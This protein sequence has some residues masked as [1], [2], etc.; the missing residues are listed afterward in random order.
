MNSRRYFLRRSL[1]FGLA[2][3]AGGLLDLEALAAEAADLH[4]APDRHLW[5]GGEHLGELTFEAEPT[6]PAGT[7]IA[8]GLDARLYTDLSRLEPDR[9]ITP[10]EEFFVRTGVPDRLDRSRPWSIDA[11]GLVKRPAV[12]TPAELEA[13][14]TSMGVHLMECAGNGRWTRFGL[15]STAEWTGVPLSPLLDDLDVLP[16]ATSV[17]VEG[18]DDHS[19][20][21]TNSTAGCGWVF[22]REQLRSSGA[23]LATAMNGRLLTPEHG[24]PVRLVVPG[25]YGCCC[26]KW[27]RRV[28]LVDGGRPATSQ[29]KEF[30]SRTHQDGEPQK[31]A[32]Y[33]PATIDR[34]ALPVRVEQWRV[35]GDLAYRVVGIDWGGD[36]G[37]RPRGVRPR[38]AG[39]LSIRFRPDAPWVP[40][41]FQPSPA[42][43]GWSLWFHPWKPPAPGRYLI[44]LRVDEAVV[45]TRRLDAG[46]YLRGVRIDEV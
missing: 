46:L 38:G 8:D 33:R 30:A 1:G 5:Q 31:A 11:G 28:E 15:I 20:T 41:Q 4:G 9:L 43:P 13:Q 21:S 16:R 23:F 7:P 2:L 22:T 45:R 44:Q 37:V 32:D 26:V 36:R 12:W 14:A 29:M 18:F 27:V 10:A 39:R 35:G 6:D 40:V 17:L 42:A 3:G 24:Q 25:W 34:A 19:R